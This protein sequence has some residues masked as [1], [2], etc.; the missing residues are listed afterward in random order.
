MKAVLKF[1]LPDEQHQFDLAT[2]AT[3][4]ALALWDITQ[5]LR[6][7]EKYGNPIDHNIGKIRETVADILYENN[8][9]LEHLMQ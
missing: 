7:F 4:M 9:N 5:K 8:V 2:N 6:E 3:G 1:D